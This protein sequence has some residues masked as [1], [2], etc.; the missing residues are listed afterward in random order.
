MPTARTTAWV[1]LKTMLFLGRE[2]ARKSGERTQSEGCG[3]RIPRTITWSAFRS[4][5]FIAMPPFCQLSYITCIERCARRHP[6]SR[7]TPFY[8]L[9]AA[10][11][12]TSTLVF[13]RVER[14]ETPIWD[15]LSLLCV[16]RRFYFRWLASR[17]EDLA[18]PSEGSL[19]PRP[20]KE[21]LGYSSPDS[22]APT[23]GIEA[24]LP[25]EV[26]GGGPPIAQRT[27]WVL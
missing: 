20:T 13:L 21:I 22:Q 18:R 7:G 3:S 5:R 11:P 10:R 4:V 17:G 16:F 2:N 8:F 14:E 6:S 23:Q 19:D 26:G 12:S 24:P 27:A 9:C 25:C 1:C 15:S